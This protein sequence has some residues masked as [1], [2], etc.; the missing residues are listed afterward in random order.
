MFEKADPNNLMRFLWEISPRTK[1]LL[2]ATA[3][4]VQLHPIEAWDLLKILA[5][6]NDMVLGTEWSEWHKA[7]RAIPV[8]MGEKEIPEELGEAWRWVRNPMP[9][10]QRVVTLS[11]CGENLV[12]KM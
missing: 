9:L 8:V 10:P 1:S 3:T 12:L 5:I 11:C 4:P 7:D 2:L 6:G